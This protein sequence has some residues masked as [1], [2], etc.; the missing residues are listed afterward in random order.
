V[1]D[2]LRALVRGEIHQVPTFV[3]SFYDYLHDGPPPTSNA[4]F[5]Q[6]VSIRTMNVLHILR[7]ATIADAPPIAEAPRIADAPPVAPAPPIAAVAAT[8]ET[9]HLVDVTLGFLL[10]S[11]DFRGAALGA[12]VARCRARPPSTTVI[13]AI[14]AFAVAAQLSG[15]A[16]VAYHAVAAVTTWWLATGGI[17]F[18][19]TWV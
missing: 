8:S 15:D 18:S 7:D 16:A 1:E 2:S 11:T 19:T 12:L 3:H 9:P 13:C 4:E 10:S 5:L 6:R 14:A 17:R